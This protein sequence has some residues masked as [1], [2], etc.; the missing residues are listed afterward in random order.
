[1]ELSGGCQGAMEAFERCTKIPGR[2]SSERGRRSSRGV[3]KTMLW[4]PGRDSGFADDE[5]SIHAITVAVV[6]W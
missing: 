1:M 4:A 5:S 3:R 6:L 2:Y